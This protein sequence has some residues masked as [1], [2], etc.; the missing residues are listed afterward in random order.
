MRKEFFVFFLIISFLNSLNAQSQNSYG[1]IIIAETKFTKITFKDFKNWVKKKNLPQNIICNYWK[2]KKLLE[3]ILPRLILPKEELQVMKINMPKIKIEEKEITNYYNNHKL[4]F[5]RKPQ[6]RLYHILFE[7][8]K[9]MEKFITSFHKLQED[10]KNIFEA[11]FKLTEEYSKKN[12]TKYWGDLGWVSPEKFPSRF[13]KKVWELENIGDYTTFQDELGYHFVMLT[14]KREPKVY[15]LEE[16]KNYITNKLIKKKKKDLWKKYLNKLM[17]KYQLKVYWD[18]LRKACLEEEKENNM[19]YLPGGEFYT[20]YN[21]EE[22]KQR[23]NIWKE[24]IQPYVRQKKPGWMNYIYKTYHKTKIKPFYIDKYEV[25]YG[26]Y[27]EFIKATR[28]KGLPEWAKLFIPGDKYPV[29]GVSWYDANA[30][31]KWKGKRLLSQDEWEFAARGKERRLY[32][33][34]NEKPDGTRGNYA[35]VNSEVP[36]KDRN[37]NDGYKHLAPVG[38]Y[39]KGAT[40]EGVYDLGGNVKEWTATINPEEKT[41]ITKGGS[42]ENHYDDMQGGDQREYP[43]ET[44]RSDIGFRCGCN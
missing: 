19:V 30:Y 6:R 8:E 21:K 32:P 12:P 44:K 9:E 5:I 18:N 14:H 38:S 22:I 42:F 26:E 25:T 31:C 28:H 27:K 15:S 40:P 33:W 43:L 7:N 39:P 1:G 20:G 17:E 37:N 35:D 10:T 11:I 23:Y 16:V 29:V 24:F 41:A 34:G 3:I 2:S 36:W 13:Q 4:E